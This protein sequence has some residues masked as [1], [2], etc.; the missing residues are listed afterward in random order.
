MEDTRL[1]AKDVKVGDLFE[2]TKSLGKNPGSFGTEY[3]MLHR[4]EDIL[5]AEFGKPYHTF[6]PPNGATMVVTRELHMLR[7]GSSAKFFT[8]KWE[9]VD[10]LLAYPQD[11]MRR[12]KLIVFAPEQD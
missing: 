11:L 5:N 12:T 6:V 10:H 7:P 2:V 9:G 4:E 1:R 8:V 3:F